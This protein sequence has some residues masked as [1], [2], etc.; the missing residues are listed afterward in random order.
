MK[1]LALIGLLAALLVPQ[2]VT[3]TVTITDCSADPHCVARGRKTIIDVPGETVVIAGPI[4]PLDGTTTIQVSAK[5]IAVDGPSGG[6]ISVTGKGQSIFLDAASVLVTGSLHSADT[7]GKIILRGV[8]TVQVQGPVN[9][10]SGGD[11]RII[12]T[13]IGCTLNVVNDLFHCNHLVLSAVGDIIWD[14]NS[15]TTFGPRDLIDIE[16]TNGSIRKSGAITIAL[17]RGR[18]TAEV[19]VDKTD[20][21]SEAVE[22]C[23]TCAG[24]P[25][26]AARTPTPTITPSGP[27]HT[28]PLSTPHPTP[29]DPKTPT[30]HVPH[31]TPTPCVDCPD[32]TNGGVESTLFMKAAGDVDVSGQH[33]H[34]AERIMITAG[35]NISLNNTE[36][37]N[38]FGKC[39][40]IVVSAGGQISIEGATL[41]DDDCR[42]TPDVS[43]LNGREAVPHTGFNGVVGTPAVDD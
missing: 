38:D 34:V 37:N 43:E 4:V 20:A 7:N 5:A 33:Y 22:F 13:G 36:L 16:A 35:G 23:A 21:V 19:P 42:G 41:V 28:A 10:D 18:L 15:V 2:T 17:A 9:V 24:T 31:A 12:C 26:P 39:G 25:T 14:G 30:P 32:T 11:V 3:A 29:T 6:Q 40:E 1:P 27:L 8:D